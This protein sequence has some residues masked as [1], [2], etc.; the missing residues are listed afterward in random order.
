MEGST[1]RSPKRDSTEEPNSLAVGL[2]QI[3]SAPRIA[4]DIE[5]EIAARQR[6]KEFM[7]AEIT[8]ID[9]EMAELRQARSAISAPSAAE[10]LVAKKSSARKSR[11]K[12]SDSDIII[13]FSRQAMLSAGKPM[14]RYE[15]LEAMNAAGIKLASKDP[16]RRIGKVLWRSEGFISTET[17]YWLTESDRSS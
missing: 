15:L 13:G 8:K 14:T 6:R 1:S 3:K 4:R 11:Q 12:P 17:G 5:A 7:L 10:T 9:S 16:A 2:P